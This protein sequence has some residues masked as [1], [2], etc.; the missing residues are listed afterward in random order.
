MD[1]QEA[2]LLLRNHLDDYRHRSYGDLVALLG[3]TQV[4]ELQGPSGKSYQVEVEVFWDQ[5]PAGAIHVLSAIDDGGWRAFKPLLE[6]FI[7]APNGTF[8]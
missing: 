5:Q 3:E 4:A 7:L 1:N 2:T 6:D 8:V